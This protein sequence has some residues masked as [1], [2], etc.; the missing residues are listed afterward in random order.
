MKLTVQPSRTDVIV[1]K[2]DALVSERSLRRLGRQRLNK[3]LLHRKEHSDTGVD[4]PAMDS[5]Q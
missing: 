5:A 1:G 4:E 3:Q 2:Q